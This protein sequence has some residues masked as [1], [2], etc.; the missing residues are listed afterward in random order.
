MRRFIRP[1]LVESFVYNYCIPLCFLLKDARFVAVTIRH[2]KLYP[3]ILKG[4]RGDE[5]V[6]SVLLA[7]DFFNT[8]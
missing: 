4:I 2:E 7:F 8:S 1:N 5:P 3:V 6:F